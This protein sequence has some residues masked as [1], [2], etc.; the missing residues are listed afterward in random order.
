MLG[1]DP[2]SL[3]S[4]EYPVS[5]HSL[6]KRLSFPPLTT[7]ASLSKINWP[8]MLGFFPGVSNF[9]LIG[10]YVYH[11]A[12]TT[13]FWLL[14]LC[15]KFWNQ[16]IWVLTFF[17]FFFF[18]MATGHIEVP[19]PGIRY[20][21]TRT[22]NPLCWVRAQTHISTATWAVALLTHCTTADTPPVFLF[23]R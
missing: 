16:V 18:F 6:L 7:L 21:N 9:I 14:W 4:C 12:N 23:S 5:Q 1:K 3:F 2:T 13:Q 10:L 20:G 19:G 17:S 15:S 8:F 11:Y 22:F